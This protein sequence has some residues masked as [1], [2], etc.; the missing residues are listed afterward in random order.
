MRIS[1]PRSAA[2]C[3]ALAGG[4]AVGACSPTVDLRGNLP[5]ERKLAEIKPGAIGRD[6]VSARLGT[7]STVA[8]FDTETWYY[9]SQKT[10]TFAF[11]EPEIIDQQV[12]AIRFDSNGLVESVDRYQLS[13][14]RPI[15]PVDRKT[16]T[17]GKELGLFEQLIGNI[18]RFTKNEE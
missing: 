14:G 18:G 11:F 5:T 16:P 6:E 17:A 13:D 2:I 8:T 9:V 3:L 10:E 4:I 7:P 12:I 15:D 1:I